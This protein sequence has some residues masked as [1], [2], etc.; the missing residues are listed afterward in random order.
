MSISE[1]HQNGEDN[2]PENPAPESESGGRRPIPF[3]LV[4]L[5][6]LLLIAATLALVVAKSVH[7]SNNLT[8]PVN[9]IPSSMH[10]VYDSSFNTAVVSPSLYSTCF[11]WNDVPAGCSNFGNPELQWF[12]PSQV[13]VSGGSL[14]L[15][16]DK[17]PV[18]GT[19]PSGQ[20]QVFQWRSGMI[21][22]YNSFKF[23]YGYV[24]FTAR[25]PSGSGMWSTFWLLPT[26]A[27]WPPE[28]DVAA[29]LGSNPKE[30]SA[31]YH[32]ANQTKVIQGNVRSPKSYSNGWH[33]YGLNWQPGSLTWYVDG[34]KFKQYNGPT[35][36]VPMYLLA[37]LAVENIFDQ[38][39]TAST[40]SSATLAIKD[41]KV[42]QKTKP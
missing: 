29:I 13:S 15:T 36:S 6:A 27:D 1:L 24:Q 33:T 14:N 34:H 40:P 2:E 23:T 7:N 28:I 18:T 11:P 38:G 10:L 5:L 37:D 32:Q 17:I 9:S 4:G 22:T 21:T 35:P 19:N 3:R 20:P 41:I 39:P 30:I 16:A 12:L 42:F 26:S 25:V 8:V 31:F